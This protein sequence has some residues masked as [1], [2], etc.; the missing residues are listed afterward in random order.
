M[1]WG[2]SLA[3]HAPSLK[4]QD[5]VLFGTDAT[6][7][8]QE[9]P[10]QL[11][12]DALYEIYFRVLETDDEYF[13]FTEAEDPRSALQRGRAK[14]PVRHRRAVLCVVCPRPLSKDCVR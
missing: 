14:T 4:G 12:G 2:V 1:S 3:R 10:Q 11:F 5:R 7:H 6:L 13:D 9:Y 8:G